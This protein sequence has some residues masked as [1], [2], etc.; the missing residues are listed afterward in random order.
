[1]KRL[2]AAL[3]FAVSVH[4]APCEHPEAQ[5]FNFMIGSWRGV[6]RTA[7]APDQI[8][9]RSEI[10]V[11]PVFNGCALQ[12]DWIVYEG[13]KELFRARLLRVFDKTSEKWMLTYIDNDLTHQVYEGRK[14]DE[15]W[16]FYRTR[17]ADGKP[18]QIRIT[19]RD[20]ANG[21]SQVIDRS[22]DGGAS[23]QHRASI[24]YRPFS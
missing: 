21:F 22:T 24:T 19:W 7:D 16:S 10:A 11:Q 15:G 20:E 18:I 23:W 9:S 13:T 2:V 8:A 4:A 14:S 6:E 12:E 5:A 3:L 1:M 17:L